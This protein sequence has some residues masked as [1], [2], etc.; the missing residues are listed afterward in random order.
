M[1]GDD[2]HAAL[3]D[4]LVRRRGVMML[5]GASDTGKTSFA[6]KLIRQR[7]QP[8]GPAPQQRKI[9]LQR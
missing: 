4:D 9:A 7:H 6:R 8:G 1:T 5:I 3:I 2:T